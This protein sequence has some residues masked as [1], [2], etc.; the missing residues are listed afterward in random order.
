VFGP[1]R[2]WRKLCNEGLHNMYSSP[3]F[4]MFIIEMRNAYKILVGKPGEKKPFGISRHRW[5]DNIKMNFERN[6][7]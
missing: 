4:I 3:N 7:V 2:G 1:K 5:E 6:M